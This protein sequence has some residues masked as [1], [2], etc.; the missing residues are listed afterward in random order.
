MVSIIINFVR[1]VYY[2]V[3]ENNILVPVL[4]FISERLF[5]LLKKKAQPVYDMKQFENLLYEKGYC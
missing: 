1:G 2:F 5:E 3:L 4:L